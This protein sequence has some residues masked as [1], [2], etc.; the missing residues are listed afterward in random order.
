VDSTGRT[1]TPVTSSWWTKSRRA[2]SDED[3]ETWIRGGVAPTLNAF[4]NAT[5]TRATV[6]AVMGDVTHTLTHE[7]HD[8]SEDGTG[9]GTP[10]IAFG[11]TQGLDI[12]P[13]T[14]ATPTLRTEGGGAAVSGATGVRRLTPVECERLQGFPDGWTDGQA[15]SNRYRQLGNAVTVPVAEWI[16]RRLMEMNADA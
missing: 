13:S 3:Y 9:C 16:G 10:V 8:A 14:D 12:Q 11:H 7:G 6:V 15:D 4:D 2:A 1:P 5:E